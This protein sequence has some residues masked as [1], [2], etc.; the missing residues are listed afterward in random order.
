MTNILKLRIMSDLHLEF[1][2]FTIPSLPDDSSTRLILAGDIGVIASPAR[3][4]AFLRRACAQFH[5][6]YYVFGN[7]EFYNG[8]TLN[9]TFDQ[10]V[11]SFGQLDGL[12]NLHLME[13]T[14]IID[15]DV[16][17]IGATL[18]TNFDNNPVTMM[19]A[20]TYM[21]DY[22]TVKF[23]DLSIDQYRLLHPDDV[24][25]Q[26]EFSKHYIMS[27]TKKHK[28]A[29]RRVVVITHHG[30]S[31]QS[32]GKQYAGDPMNSAFV[33]ALDYD[34]E[35]AAPNLL[36]HGHVHSPFDYNIGETRVLVNPRGY[37]GPEREAGF[38][39]HLLVEV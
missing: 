36:I 33:S 17:F 10:C 9:V 7:H 12:D 28:A 29:G 27:E 34:I 39:P 22:T 35:D 1:E 6:V 13:N 15:E 32:V 16:A 11:R 38:N 30:V 8:G 18:W 3:L 26:F 21:Y 4:I 20:R 5:S 14:T 24:V 19:A 25:R 23:Y 2:D 31:Y 37:P